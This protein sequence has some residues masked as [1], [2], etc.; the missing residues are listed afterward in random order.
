[1]RS[2]AFLKREQ[3]L[4]D[5]NYKLTWLGRGRWWWWWKRTTISTK[6][7]GKK[8]RCNWTKNK[9]KNQET[10][11]KRRNLNASRRPPEFKILKWEKGD[12]HQQSLGSIVLMRFCMPY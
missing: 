1:M 3:T 2:L 11:K 5:H 6:S 10:K 8:R 7:T 12:I 9:D 4:I